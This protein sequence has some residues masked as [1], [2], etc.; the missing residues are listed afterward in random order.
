MDEIQEEEIRRIAREEIRK[1]ERRKEA[2]EMVKDPSS[3][4]KRIIEVR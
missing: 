3:P 1:A 2:K 4:R